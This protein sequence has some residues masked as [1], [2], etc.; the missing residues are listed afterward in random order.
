MTTSEKSK[1]LDA[2]N[3]RSPPKP[4]QSAFYSL[5][6]SVIGGQKDSFNNKDILHENAIK[7][8]LESPDVSER[9]DSNNRSGIEYD[10]RTEEIPLEEE[11]LSFEEYGF[12]DPFFTKLGVTLPPSSMSVFV[13]SRAKI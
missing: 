2:Q 13:T 7:T 12:D 6:P 1:H 10:N 9:G 11:E 4:R 8:F 5:V 3:E